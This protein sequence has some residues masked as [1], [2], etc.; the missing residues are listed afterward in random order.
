MDRAEELPT[1]ARW[2]GFARWSPLWLAVGIAVSYLL[3]LVVYWVLLAIPRYGIMG[4]PPP[5]PGSWLEHPHL[6]G[7]HHFALLA[8]FAGLGLAGWRQ[9]RTWPDR[10]NGWAM[11]SAVGNL[12]AM[13]IGSVA[14]HQHAVEGGAWPPGDLSLGILLCLVLFGLAFLTGI[15]ASV[16]LIRGTG[17]SRGWILA[18]LGLF[19][20]PSIGLFLCHAFVHPIFAERLPDAD[21][22]LVVLAEVERA[23]HFDPDP[24]KDLPVL[25]VLADGSVIADG[26]V[27][28]EGSS[29]EDT[30][31][32]E[33]YLADRASRMYLEHLDPFEQTGPLIPYDPVLILPDATTDFANVARLARLCSREGIRIWKLQFGVHRAAWPRLGAYAVYLPKDI[34]VRTTPVEGGAA[35]SDDLG[36]EVLVPGTKLDP[37]RDVPWRGH[38]PFRFGPDRV[39]R[40]SWRDWSSTDPGELWDL[41]G[42]QDLEVTDVGPGVVWSDVARALSALTPRDGWSSVAFLGSFPDR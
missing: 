26:V 35:I 3:H 16:T 18:I 23:P 42:R 41:E 40:Y 12:A 4:G 34:G 9:Q 17:G 28:L 19:M 10:L 30:S 36:I 21:L 37:E 31:G 39:V 27:L 13:W 38:G 15:A 22:E 5:E 8:V 25:H 32:L 33:R 14:A 29:P 11:A 1:R 6:P 7:P 2:P 20:P 24:R